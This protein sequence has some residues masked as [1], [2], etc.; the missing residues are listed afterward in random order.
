MGR[1][2]GRV[3]AQLR[4]LTLHQRADDVEADDERCSGIFRSFGWRIL[5]RL[6]GRSFTPAL[7]CARF[8]VATR[9]FSI[10]SR[11]LSSLPRTTVW[12]LAIKLLACSM[13]DCIWS[14]S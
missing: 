8:S 10:V 12:M 14:R 3:F 7:S 6:H 1:I 13:V 9:R 4:I 11:I 5:T 2:G